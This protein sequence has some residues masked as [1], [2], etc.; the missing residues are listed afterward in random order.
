[1]SVICQAEYAFDVERFELAGHLFSREMHPPNPRPE[2]TVC[3]VTRGHRG[4]G[5]N[6]LDRA[7][8]CFCCRFEQ[9]DTEVNSVVA[10]EPSSEPKV[11]NY[12]LR[13]DYG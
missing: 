4:T 8:R 2:A 3:T 11:K 7:T 12:S 5:R 13:G 9:W 10:E 6:R 1:M